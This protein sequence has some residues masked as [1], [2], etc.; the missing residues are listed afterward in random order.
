MGRFGRVCG[1]DQH[2]QTLITSMH[3]NSVSL[4]GDDTSGLRCNVRW[5]AFFPVLLRWCVG[6]IQRCAV[7][8][9]VAHPLTDENN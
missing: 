6:A 4:Q 7:L 5:F 2:R 3:L 8:V 9:L 1:S